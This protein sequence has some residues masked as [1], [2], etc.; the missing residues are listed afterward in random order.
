MKVVDDGLKYKDVDFDYM[1]KQKIVDLFEAG[2]GY[3]IKGDLRRGFDSFRLMLKVLAGRDYPS[4]KLLENLE[5][6]LVDY[7]DR[8]KGAKPNRSD[9][10]LLRDKQSETLKVLLDAYVSE[11]V[12]VFTIVGLWLSVKVG[13]ED[14]DRQLSEENFGSDVSLLNRK[15]DLLLGL[16]VDVLVGY[17]SPNIV[18]D[19]YSKLRFDKAFKSVGGE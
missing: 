10:V 7:F 11:V 6:A 5:G 8:L 13:F 19:V 12:K 9:K 3:L 14:F 2:A 4:K 18:S 15:K 17:L 16:E 1:L